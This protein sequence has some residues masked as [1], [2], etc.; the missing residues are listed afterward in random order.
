MG[1]MQRWKGKVAGAVGQF[2]SLQMVAGGALSTLINAAGT[3]SV[4]VATVGSSA[5]NTLQTMRSF[6]IPANLLNSTSRGLFV[7]AWGR[8]AGNAAPKSIN[9]KVGGV[10]IQ[11][12]TSTQSGAVWML[13]GTVG[14]V[15]ANSQRTVFNG[16]IGTTVI[17]PVS[18]ADTSV[19]TSAIT[20]SVTATDDSAAQS[21]LLV[22][23]LLIEMF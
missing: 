12:G 7:S 16:Q 6:P 21:N 2:K 13:T 17:A 19:N 20:V 4:N 22:D 8:F 15:G 23:G 9:L 3:V 11:S 1:I 14:R 5:T 18:L 10:Q